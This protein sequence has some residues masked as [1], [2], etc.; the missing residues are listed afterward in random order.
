MDGEFEKRSFAV[1]GNVFSVEEIVRVAKNQT[2]LLYCVLANLLVYLVGALLGPLMPLAG[3]AVFI[4]SIVFLVKLRLAMKESLLLTI[5]AAIFMVV[6][7]IGLFILVVNT[8]AATKIL[9]CAGLKVGFMGV[10]SSELANFI[11]R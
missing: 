1:A 9:R 4:C 2:A 8:V 7:L 5:I 10:S 3:V 6:P 11:N